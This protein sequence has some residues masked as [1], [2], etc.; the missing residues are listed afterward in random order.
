M[1]TIFLEAGSSEGAFVGSTMAVGSGILVGVATGVAGA[2]QA[3]KTRVNKTNMN[4]NLV[5]ISF[6]S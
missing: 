4:A 6:H 1:S 5:F 3:A 2:P